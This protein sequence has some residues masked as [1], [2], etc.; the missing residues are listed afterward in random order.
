MSPKTI[1]SH[2]V[3][4]IRK[5]DFLNFL[6]INTLLQRCYQSI[7]TNNATSP[8]NCPQRLASLHA[9]YVPIHRL[10]YLSFCFFLNG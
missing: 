10:P 9:F 4:Q 2:S 3:T 7:L 6:C 8:K 1:K 5:T